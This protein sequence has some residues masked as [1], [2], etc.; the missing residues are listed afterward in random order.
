MNRSF[1][2]FEVLAYA[3][4]LNADGEPQYMVQLG[5]NHHPIR[6]WTVSYREGYLLT[7]DKA[8]LDRFIAGKLFE[9]FKGDE[10]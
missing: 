2:N 4:G 1:L 8:H 6:T 5:M 9:M 7:Q 3:S 10:P